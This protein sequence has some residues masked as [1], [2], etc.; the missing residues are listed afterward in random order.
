VAINDTLPGYQYPDEVS[1]VIREQHKKD[2]VDAANFLNLSTIDV[3]SLQH[4]F[5]IF[6]GND[7]NYIIYLLQN[8]KKPVVTTLHT[9]LK[10]PPQGR[11]KVLKTICAL[12]TLVVV[13]S[14]HAK[15]ILADIYD[16]P[17]E[18]I[19][20]IY[21]GAPDVP[22]LDP[23]YYKD[24][25]QAEE[26]RV[27]LTFGLINPQKGIEYVIEA[28]PEV[29]RQ[30][31]DALYL[32][33]GATH[34]SI[35][36]R[37]GEQY[38]FFLEQMVKAKRLEHNISFHNKF[39]SLE[40]L[41]RFII[42]ADIYLT[43][44]LSKEQIVSGTLT[45]AVACGKA[46]ISTPYWYAEEML[47]EG[48]GRLVPF[49][50]KDTISKE[51]IELLGNEILRNRLRKQT[52]QFGRRMV[53]H[54][55]GSVYIE[56]FERALLEYGKQ[57]RARRIRQRP[58]D[59]ISLPEVKL[60]HLKTLTD[61]TGIIRNA[62]FTTPD[63]YHGYSTDDNA[64]ALVVTIMNWMLFKDESII[65]LMHIYLAFLNYAFN[66]GEK[67]IRSLMSYDRLWVEE[68]GTEDS[69]GRT[70]WALGYTVAYAPTDSILG[71]AVHLFKQALCPSLSFNSPRAWAYSILGCANYLKRFGG[72]TE[73]KGILKELA[74][75]LFKLFKDNGT[76][77]WPWCEDIVTYDNA[78]LPQA[79]ISTYKC[80]K[81]EEILKQGLN[82]LKWLLDIQ[83]D[84]VGK[85][86]SII[87][88]N[89]GFRQGEE[90]AIFDQK[91][92]EIAAII[93]A[94]NEA[95]I[96]TEDYS[97]H[98]MIERC[99]SWFFGSNDLQETLYDFNTGGC[100]DGLNSTGVDKNQG[101]EATLSWLLALHLM[102]EVAHHKILHPEDVDS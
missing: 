3:I 86:I 62:I 25:F 16:V 71:L 36:R 90:K 46:I 80:I 97:W 53:W 50:D 42:A 28:M 33:V 26:R 8:L 30:F 11:K 77:D 9:I 66:Q 74:L 81:E 21:H 55:V 31:P 83:T 73:V 57:V 6:G 76:E 1:F 5:D 102:Y 95:L 19:V 17:E 4:E 58:V 64:R 10:D 47:S 43:P 18:K 7:G 38:R 35:K 101:A 41:V 84:P 44:Y 48:R 51:L 40:Q 61:D 54:E 2:Y 39:V 20:M 49:R 67:R 68:V 29:V 72:D 85:Y 75:K 96:I 78:R 15:E 87:G 24:Q 59:R 37:F 27:I 91:P 92:I 63:R 56:I 69:H 70:L 14:N 89:G 65:P 60:N 94:C 79:L 88:S 52:Y 23:S 32:I 13:Q 98:E 93:D 99:F 45:Y 82:S 22:F 100:F 12:S 34:P